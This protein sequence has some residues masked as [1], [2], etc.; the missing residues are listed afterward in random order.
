MLQVLVTVYE[1]AKA[2]HVVIMPT[3]VCRSWKE[4][5]LD[6]EEVCF[7]FKED[8]ILTAK[9]AIILQDMPDHWDVL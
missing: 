5:F 4:I 8:E 6:I 7:S 2:W 3:T 1:V 9:L